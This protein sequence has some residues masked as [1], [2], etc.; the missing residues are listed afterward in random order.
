MKARLFRKIKLLIILLGELCKKKK[1]RLFVLSIK[2]TIIL[3]LTAEL[4]V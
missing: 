2:N 3:R 4:L 1:K